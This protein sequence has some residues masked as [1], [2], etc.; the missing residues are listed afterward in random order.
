MTLV[1]ISAQTSFLT[2]GNCLRNSPC[3]RSTSAVRIAF[4]ELSLELSGIKFISFLRKSIAYNSSLLDDLRNFVDSSISCRQFTRIDC[5][6]MQL[7]FRGVAYGYLVDRNGKQ[8]NY[9]GGG[10]KEGSG[11]NFLHTLFHPCPSPPYLSFNIAQSLLNSLV[12]IS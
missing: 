7:T 2:K 10:P 12:L 8:M 4:L 6:G 3:Y 5:Y 1:P 9:F 11:K